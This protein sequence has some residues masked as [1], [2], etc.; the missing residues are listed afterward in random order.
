MS[1]SD[2]FN[3]KNI[4]ISGLPG[5]G[6]TTLLKILKENELF[7]FAGWKG[8]SG[9][10]FMRAYAEEKGLFNEAGALHHDATHYED[11]F[12]VAVDMGMRDKLLTEEG[13]VLE[14]WLS[15]FLSQQVPDVLKI[16]MVCSNKAVKVDRIVNRDKVTPEQAIENMHNR[17]QANV[18]KWKRLYSTQWQEWVVQTGVRPSTAPIDFWHEDLYDI[19]IDTYSHNQQEVLEIVLNAIIKK[20]T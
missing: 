15:G 20:T 14:S 7:Q 19:V 17:Y 1:L 8:F 5:S 3:Y 11:E 4:T 12:D 2:Q 18:T 16:L 6:S 9:G 10:E 13:W